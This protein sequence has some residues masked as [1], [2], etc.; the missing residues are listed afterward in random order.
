MCKEY[1]GWTNYATW[2]VGLWMDND[3]GS[4]HYARELAAEA[5]ERAPT[6]DSV[7]NGIWTEEEAAKFILA[8]S[9]KEWVKSENPL[10][11][12]LCPEC[13]V[14]ISFGGSA[15]SDMTTWALGQVNWQEIAEGILEEV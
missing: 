8:D 3:E 6:H 15:Y 14:L 4:Y 7:L 5:R 13:N 9:L 12:T 1:Q 2:C 10:E 11:S